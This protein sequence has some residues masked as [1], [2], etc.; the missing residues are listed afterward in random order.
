MRLF[1]WGFAACSCLLAAAPQEVTF[2]KTVEPI[3]QA[4]CQGCHRPGE[5]AP[6]SLLSYKDARPW[7]KAIKDAVLLRKMPPWFADP[8][9]SFSNNRR[10]SKE[11]TDALVAWADSG[12]QRGRPERCSAAQ[13]VRRRLGHGQARRRDPDAGRVRSAASETVDYTYIV[14]P[15]GFTEDKW[16]QQVEVGPETDP[17]C[18][19]LSCW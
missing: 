4:R 9:Q 5:A 13:D 17:W 11:E 14:V 15:T 2:H 7:A 10:L 18:I 1:I 6:M 16:V 19:T 12:R 3:L 8:A